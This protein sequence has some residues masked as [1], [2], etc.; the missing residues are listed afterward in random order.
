MLILTEPDLRS[1]LKMN[2][3][4]DAVER[5]F[6]AMARGDAVVPD[7]LRLEVP[8][9]NAVL[10]E[11]PA[12]LKRAVGAAGNEPG[13]GT[14][15]VGVFSENRGRSL[16]VVQAVYLLLDPETGVPLALMEG[17][18]LTGIRTAA[19]SAVATKQM[20]TPGP[21][22]L[23]VFG[24]GVQA[25]FHIDAMI[26]AGNIAR[27]MIA[28]R[29]VQRAHELAEQVRS[30][31]RIPCEVV[32]ADEAASRA[33]L[34]C[35]CTTSPAPLFDGA[36]IRAGTHIN[37]VGAFTPLNR[38]LD[39]AAVL[40]SRVI[41][42]AETAAGKEAGEIQIPLIEGAIQASHVKGTLADVVSGKVAG[43]ESNEQ[44]TLF[45]SCGLAIEDLLTAKLAYERATAR[46]IGT[47]VEM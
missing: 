11:M 16:E 20:A 17:R 42:D 8:A 7:R 34:I 14:K 9:A 2:E 18:F 21:K 6:R 19:T 1:V 43:R 33:D 31:H 41:I 3:V 40:R 22:Q 26:E 5:G 39:T 37:A 29:T 10:L 23:A 44:V 36:I 13:L 32:S 46:N 38:E 4:I 24:A 25:R 47:H 30:L 12:Y 27:I 45:R 35:T 15:I 28:S